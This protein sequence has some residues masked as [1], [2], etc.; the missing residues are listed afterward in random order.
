MGME[1]QAA[2]F[3]PFLSALK[4]SILLVDVFQH[5]TMLPARAD[6]VVALAGKLA[7]R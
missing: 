6:F 3:L 5:T 7:Y 4:I 2:D 1:M